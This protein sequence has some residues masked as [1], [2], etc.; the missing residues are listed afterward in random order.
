MGVITIS[1]Q[2]GSGGGGVGA[3]VAQSLAYRYIDKELI[4]RVALEAGVGLSEAERYDER[5]EHVFLRVLRQAFDSGHATAALGPHGGIWGAQAMVLALPRDERDR[6]SR[7]EEDTC[8]NLTQKIT[9]R[10]AHEGSVVIMGRGAQA[11]LAKWPHTMHVRVVA[12][13]DYRVRK[14]AQREGITADEADMRIE[15][16]DRQRARYIRRH[17]GVDWDDPALYHLIVNTGETGGQAAG[18]IVVEAARCLSAA[19]PSQPKT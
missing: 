8:V 18:C 9:W 10:L 17:Y 15:Q 2:Y 14:V 12:P 11:F 13:V 19:A 5:A 16:I 7:L 4:V 3:S 1:R 6:Q